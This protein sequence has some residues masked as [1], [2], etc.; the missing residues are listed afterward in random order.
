MQEAVHALHGSQT[1]MIAISWRGLRGPDSLLASVRREIRK[2]FATNIASL[3][4]VD[5]VKHPA[6]AIR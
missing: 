1:W 4:S 2:G 6:L 3:T 5:C